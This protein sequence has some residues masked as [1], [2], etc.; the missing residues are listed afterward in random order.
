MA[1]KTR[2]PVRIVNLRKQD[3]TPAGSPDQWIILAGDHKSSADA[4]KAQPAHGAG[5]YWVGSMFGE[6]R[7][8]KAKK[9]PDLLVVDDGKVDDRPAETQVE[10]PPPEAD[11]SDESDPLAILR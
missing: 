10:V 2:T 3:G 7:T 11:A 6:R 8:L 4:I 5:T 9:Q 1:K